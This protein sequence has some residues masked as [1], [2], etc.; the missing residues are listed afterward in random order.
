MNWAQEM[1]DFASKQAVRIARNYASELCI[2]DVV[3]ADDNGDNA[4]IRW[5]GTVI[6]S[7]LV[8]QTPFTIENVIDVPVYGIDSHYHNITPSLVSRVGVTTSGESVYFIPDEID[9][10]PAL[11]PDGTYDM[12]IVQELTQD[13][14]EHFDI[15]RLSLNHDHGGR[16]SLELPQIRLWRGVKAG[17]SVLVLKVNPSC[18]VILCRL[19]LSNDEGA[20]GVKTYRDTGG[21]SL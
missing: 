19:V 10:T 18:F 12:E 6:G 5:N 2:C 7:D 16:T 20:Q 14:Q 15:T 9:L 4:S 8:V 11:L 21:K 13:L 1:I 17:D 3:S